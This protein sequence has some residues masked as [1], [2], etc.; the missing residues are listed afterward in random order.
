MTWYNRQAIA[1][2]EPGRSSAALRRRNLLETPDPRT[3][4][5]FFRSLLD[6]LSGG[7]LPARGSGALIDA[8]WKS[9][10]KYLELSFFKARKLDGEAIS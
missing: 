3:Q 8:G 6:V 7:P 5:A 4:A 1:K 2:P 9:R 10:A